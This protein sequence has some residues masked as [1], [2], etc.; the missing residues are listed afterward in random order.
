M[1][2][3]FGSKNEIPINVRVICSTSVDLEQ[4]VKRGLF[5]EDL[6]YKLSSASIY[7]PPLRER[8]E[9]IPILA[10]YFV[11]KFNQLKGKK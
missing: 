3:N 10:E 2:K 11:Q 4:L 1:I 6:F 7:L 8:R 5:L 9:D